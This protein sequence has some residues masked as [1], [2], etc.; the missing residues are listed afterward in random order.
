MLPIGLPTLAIALE[1][2]PPAFCC[3][4]RVCWVGAHRHSSMPFGD[5]CGAALGLQQGSEDALVACLVEREIG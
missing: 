2:E 5:A 4:R 1:L 3:Q